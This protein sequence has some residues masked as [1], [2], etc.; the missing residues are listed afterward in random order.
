MDQYL[1]FISNHYLLCLALVVVTFLLLQ[2]FF[3]STFKKYESLSPLIAVTKMNSDE[4]VV[5]DVRELPDYVKGHI[6]NAISVPLSKFADKLD[7]LEKYKTKPIIVVCQ[8]GASSTTACKDLIK[9]NFEHVFHLIGGMQ[10]WEDNKF[11][12]KKSSKNKN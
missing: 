9:A 1:E 2:D 5:I 4:T 11:P 8:N 10:S 12:I 3:E 7:S 6:E